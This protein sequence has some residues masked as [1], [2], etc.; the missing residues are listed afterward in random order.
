MAKA[1]IC[2]GR[3]LADLPELVQLAQSGGSTYWTVG[4]EAQPGDRA[5][6]YLVRPYSSFVAHGSIESQP[7]SKLASRLGWPGHFMTKVGNVQLFPK[8]ITLRT[9]KAKFPGWRYLWRPKKSIAIPEEL[10]T[11]FLDFLA[12]TEPRGSAV[13]QEAAAFEGTSKLVAHLRRERNAQLIQLKKQQALSVNGTLA[14]EACDFDFGKS[15]GDLGRGFCEVHHRL[16][17]SAKQGKRRT[18]TDDLSVLCSNCH[19]MAHALLRQGW[20][21][22]AVPELRRRMQRAN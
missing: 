18:R 19:R 1:Y 9:A 8:P 16:P 5:V 6:F 4:A 3:E 20:R 22:D 2:F 15:Y 21:G 12:K 10:E 14:C 11:R 13:F 7:S 17:L